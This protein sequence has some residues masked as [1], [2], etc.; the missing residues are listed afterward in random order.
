MII[1]K[2][3]YHYSSKPV[4]LED[5]EIINYIAVNNKRPFSFKP[6]G[7]WISIEDYKDED[8]VTWDS[9]CIKENF[10]IDSLKVKNKI[11]LHEKAN[12]LLLTTF[13]DIYSFGK[14]NRFDIESYLKTTLGGNYEES[15][16]VIFDLDSETT[17]EILQISWDKV[18]KKY[19]GIFIAPYNWEARW[20]TETIWYY[21]WDCASGCIWNID[22]IKEIKEEST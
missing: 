9:W 8:D 6:A 22:I 20:H 2:E 19:D 7:L 21:G 13:K 16:D 14:E 10:R 15:D 3:I 17:K 5:L 1:P 11:I 4:K 12:I 18:I